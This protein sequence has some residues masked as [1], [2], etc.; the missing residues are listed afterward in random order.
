MS[1]PLWLRVRGTGDV[2]SAQQGS[3]QLGEC[4]YRILLPRI[5]GN[6][7]K[8]QRAAGERIQAQNYWWERWWV[9]FKSQRHSIDN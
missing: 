4:S 6:L 2:G 9:V 5:F 3:S 1:V 8:L 7:P